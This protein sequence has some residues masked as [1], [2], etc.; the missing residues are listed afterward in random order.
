MKPGFILKGRYTIERSIR[1]GGMG[2]IYLARDGNLADSLCAVK[3]MLDLGA[4][5]EDYLPL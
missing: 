3:Q 2:A 4:D 1:A 5:S